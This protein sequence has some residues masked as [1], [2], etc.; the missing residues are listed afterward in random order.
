MNF[1][2]NGDYDRIEL[3]LA[4]DLGSSFVV[5]TT[6]HRYL[7]EGDAE[8]AVAVW[9]DL[10]DGNAFRAEHEL[11]AVAVA[12]EG[13]QVIERAIDAAVAMGAATR[14]SE[15]LYFLGEALVFAGA[16]EEGY[17]QIRRAIDLNYC[18][19]TALEHGTIWEPHRKDEDFRELLRLAR[20]CRDRFAD[21]SR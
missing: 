20:E 11:I 4:L 5:E 12:A 7:S 15:V 6:G 18:A 9:R 21:P 8:R 13:D 2:V 3:F 1:V 19:A 17:R 14:D 16:A 10:P